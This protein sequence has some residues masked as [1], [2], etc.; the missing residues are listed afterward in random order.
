MVITLLKNQSQEKPAE[1]GR[2]I[3]AYQH[4]PSNSMLQNPSQDSHLRLNPTVI[5]LLNELSSY[6][7]KQ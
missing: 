4:K 3:R 2:A 1:T 6:L 7:A 5:T